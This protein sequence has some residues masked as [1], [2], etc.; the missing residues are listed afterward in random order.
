MGSSVYTSMVALYLIDTFNL[1]A[2]AVGYVTLS[3][4]TVAV[5]TNFLF[6]FLSGK[7][8]M[9]FVSHGGALWFGIAL[10]IAPL[11][12]GVLYGTN[13]AYPF[14]LGAGCCVGAAFVL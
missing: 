6:V 1:A 2:V 8:G 9:W 4:S 3:G 14:Y 11:L 13:T 10:F 7:F 5:F 12:H